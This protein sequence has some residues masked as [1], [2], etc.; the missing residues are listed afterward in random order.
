MLPT[1]L[2]LAS[3]VA[4]AV[5]APAADAASVAYT[6]ETGNLVLSS[7]DGAAKL[8]LTADG[9]PAEPYYA[10]A[11]SA[12]G[13]TVAAHRDQFDK[14]RSVLH[15]FSPAD[16]SHTAAN[17]MPADALAS[18]VVAPIGLDIDPE[19]KVV[20]FGYS[21]CGLTQGC[22]NRTYGYWLTFA[23]HGPA[24]PSYPQGSTGL[25]AP[26]F[27]GNR[28]VSTDSYKVMVQESVNAPFNDGHAGWIDPGS[29]RFWAA[30]VAPGARAIALQYQ[31]SSGHFGLVLASGDGVLGGATELKCFVPAVGEAGEASWSPDGVQ[32]AWQDD[33]GVKVGT[34]DLGVAP[35]AG[36]VCAMKAAPRVIA[37]GGKDPNFGGADVVAMKAARAPG[38][39]GGG[40]GGGAV[41]DPGPEPAAQI[42][43]RAPA[44][45]KRAV[46]V[47]VSVPGA[48][49]VR[50]VLTRGAKVVGSGK[51]TAT[52][53]GVVAVR[54][55]L[56]HRM[57][58]KLALRVEWRGAD[59]RVATATAKV[60]AR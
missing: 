34:P 1:R 35:G 3:L 26:S 51:A 47:S 5:A 16:G 6:D 32:L 11:Q 8:P 13:V 28:I 29:A 30:E 45:M 41:V 12:N 60:K 27:Y 49:S 52:G 39:G 23:D 38:G 21:T 43:L 31:D 36:D 20:A 48:G 4:C 17:V 25:Y 33:E 19:G 24:K 22:I 57:H 10:P 56:R 14:L 15:A 7:A 40:A 55:K 42:T 2:L 46:K 37:A 18:S 44:R 59:G 54:A 53:A 9:T 50:A 58:R